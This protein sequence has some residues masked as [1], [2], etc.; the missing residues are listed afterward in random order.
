MFNHYVRRKVLRLYSEVEGIIVLI[1]AW[2]FIAFVSGRVSIVQCHFAHLDT[3]FAPYGLIVIA[4][5]IEG[6]N[7]LDVTLLKYWFWAILQMMQ[8]AKSCVST[9]NFWTL[10]DI[11]MRTAKGIAAVSFWWGLVA[12]VRRLQPPPK[13][14][15]ESPVLVL[16]VLGTEDSG[17]PEML[18]TKICPDDY[19]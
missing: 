17:V 11:A 3:N 9:L 10:L 5:G 16:G 12:E 18:S 1:I 7:S 2:H 19:L 13:D 15:A 8:D 6:Q 14:L 4:S